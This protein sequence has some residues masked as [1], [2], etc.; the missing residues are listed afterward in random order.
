[1]G[2]VVNTSISIINNKTEYCMAQLFKSRTYYNEDGKSFWDYFYDDIHTTFSDESNKYIFKMFTKNAAVSVRLGITLLESVPIGNR[3][4]NEP[5]V[6]WDMPLDVMLRNAYDEIEQLTDKFRRYVD[7]FISDVELGSFSKQVFTH[8]LPGCLFDMDTCTKLYTLKC[9]PETNKPHINLGV[10][11]PSTDDSFVPVII[12]IEDT[13]GYG[14]YFDKK[15]V[16]EEIYNQIMLNMGHLT[17][18]PDKISCELHIWGI[19]KKMPLYEFSFEGMA[20]ILAEY[21]KD[22]VTQIYEDVVPDED[23]TKSWFSSSCSKMKGE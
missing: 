12:V 17:T 4:I 23:D 16:K 21:V 14:L 6:I 1:M 22:I 20:D 19:V 7:I 15:F 10:Y 9:N 18:K 11:L 8:N 2:H 3:Q 5:T 13:K